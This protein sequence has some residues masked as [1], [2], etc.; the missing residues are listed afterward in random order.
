MILLK[1]KNGQIVERYL[2]AYE[3]GKDLHLTFESI[4]HYVYTEKIFRNRFYITETNI[5]K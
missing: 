1:N 3:A 4:Y 2:N 5:K